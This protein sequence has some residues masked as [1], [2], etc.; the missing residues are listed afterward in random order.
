MTARLILIMWCLA[1]AAPLA[2]SLW[3]RDA[4]AAEEAGVPDAPGIAA[5]RFADY[6]AAYYTARLARCVESVRVNPKAL[7]EYD[8]AAGACFRLGRLDEAIDWMRRK[9]SVL[10]AVLETLDVRRVR[11]HT[12]RAHCNLATFFMHRWAKGGCDRGNVEDVTRARDEFVAAFS[13]YED[14]VVLRDRFH[15]TFVDA[16]LKGGNHGARVRSL[17]DMFGI[18]PRSLFDNP[19]REFQARGIE[20]QDAITA[21]SVLIVAGGE[22]RG[23]DLYFAL[24]A[25]L[26]ADGRMDHCWLM[27]WRACKLAEAGGQSWIVPALKGSALKAAIM[28]A[29]PGGF[30]NNQVRYAD[31][32]GRLSDEARAVNE[33]R[34]AYLVKALE[35]GRHPDTQRDFWKQLESPGAPLPAQ[36]SGFG[37]GILAPAAAIG[38]LVLAVAGFA[39]YFLI[40]R[41]RATPTVKDI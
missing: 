16:V 25:A 31:E 18:H 12:Y 40:R 29:A 7:E 38:L 33:A 37:S 6:P 1:A 3:D 20:P 13:K 9:Q 4:I 26:A 41:H 21:L 15:F 36:N 30:A 14:I 22:D 27:L 32:L 8:D 19:R 35:Q 17:P 28:A 2:A 23:V 10:P 11:L 34:N 39:A 24:A 5:G